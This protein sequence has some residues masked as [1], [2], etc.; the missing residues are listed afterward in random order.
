MDNVHC[1]MGS[2]ESLVIYKGVQ[3]KATMSSFAREYLHKN[4]S[5]TNC[6]TYYQ[7]KDSRFAKL[8]DSTFNANIFLLLDP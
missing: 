5:E 3:I 4:V 2:V 6:L 8:R 7:I 1:R